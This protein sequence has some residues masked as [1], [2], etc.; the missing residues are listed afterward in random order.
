MADVMWTDVVSALGTAVGAIATTG[1]TVLVARFERRQ[2]ARELAAQKAEEVRSAYSQW[3]R[4]MD[5][6]VDAYVGTSRD[7]DLEDV[8]PAVALFK[9][10]GVDTRMI[11]A[12]AGVLQGQLCALE[13]ISEPGSRWLADLDDLHAPVPE[14]IAG[15]VNGTLDVVKDYV[16]LDAPDGQSDHDWIED[17]F[18]TE[19]E[20][21]GAPMGEGT[22]AGPGPSRV[23]AMIDRGLDKWLKPGAPADVRIRVGALLR[24]KIHLEEALG[25]CFTGNFSNWNTDGKAGNG[26]KFHM[27]MNG[28]TRRVKEQLDQQI[29]LAAVA[30]NQDRRRTR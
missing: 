10:R 14:I 12:Q 8:P 15:E 27:A 29:E 5:A 21:P 20:R 19:L 6:R 3:S 7:R 28:L 26:E 11:E 17:G 23:E 24:Y 13:M 1:V 30:L 25:V 22:S 9:A 2:R 4:Q 18:W 16:L